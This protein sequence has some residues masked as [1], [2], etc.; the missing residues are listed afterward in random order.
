MSANV[1]FL[2]LF[3]KAVSLWKGSVALCGKIE[4]LCKQE[5][6]KKAWSTDPTHGHEVSLQFSLCSTLEHRAICPIQL[7]DLE[8][9]QGSLET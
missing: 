8:V 1:A 7:F 6:G 9:K 3:N 2:R 5:L 4:R